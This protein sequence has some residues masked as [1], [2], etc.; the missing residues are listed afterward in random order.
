MSKGRPWSRRGDSALNQTGK[1]VAG[2][3]AFE[4]WA[5]V[6]GRSPGLGPEAPGGTV[7][8]PCHSLL[9]LGLAARAPWALSP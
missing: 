6:L 2:A 8:N 4:P 3:S 9:K 1:D 5:V 7:D